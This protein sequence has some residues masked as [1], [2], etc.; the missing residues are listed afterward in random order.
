M[1]GGGAGGPQRS[2][3]EQQESHRAQQPPRR[4]TASLPRGIE[5]G[6]E[7]AHGARR[8]VAGTMSRLY[9]QRGQRQHRD[10]YENRTSRVEKVVRTA[11]HAREQQRAGDA[12]DEEADADQQAEQRHA[13]P[14]QPPGAD[15][16][17]AQEPARGRGRGDVP[18]GQH[19]PGPHRDP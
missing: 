2:H 11:G 5:P 16:V 18:T 15:P 17:T 8:T 4:G 13:S 10:G 1:P 9:H 7:S 3:V 12:V 14:D 6:G 19:R